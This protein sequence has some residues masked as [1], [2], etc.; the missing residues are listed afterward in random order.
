MT[1]TFQSNTYDTVIV[2]AGSAGCALAARLSEDS[3]RRVLLLE[4]GR[5]YGALNQY[6]WPLRCAYSNAFS[7]PGN[8]HSWTFY[9]ALASPEQRYPIT[10][11][12]V[13]GGSSAVNGSLFMRASASE[14]DAWAAQG[15]SEWSYAKVLP[16]LIR[17]E[18]DLDFGHTSLH[19]ETGP[20]P[21]MRNG[22]DD[23]CEV[24]QAFLEAC[25]GMGYPWDDDMND[26]SGRGGIGLLP[27]NAP[28]GLRQNTGACY[29]EPATHRRSLQVKPLATATKVLFSRG[30]AVGVEAVTGVSV[31]H[32]GADEVVLCAGGIKSP[33]LLM[34]SG[35]G[36]PKTLQRLGV[37]VIISLPNVGRNLMDH[38][39]VKLTYTCKSYTPRVGPR[40]L[41]EVA[42]HTAIEGVGA[43]AEVRIMPYVY[44]KANLLFATLPGLGVRERMAALGSVRNLRGLLAST[45]KLGARVLKSE[46][47]ELRALQIGISLGVERSRGEIRPLTSDWSQEPTISFG[48][49]THPDDIRRLRIGVRMAVAIFERKEFAARLGATLI[50]PSEDDLRNDETLDRWIRVHLT[51]SYHTASTCRMGA[52]R[53]IACE[54]GSVADQLGRVHGAEGLRI[55]DLSIL[56]KLV[57]RP[58]NS[59]AI[60]IGERI[61]DFMSYAKGGR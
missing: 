28:L 49:L 43:D 15:N 53:D 26:A 42:L 5:S 50:N 22:K 21:V 37:P 36:E 60:L 1:S 19:G 30:K 40:P 47:A 20:I 25:L 9:A 34:L 18:S 14:F 39:G 35:V 41:A 52:A 56:P 23:L 24:S 38:P 4:A 46:I 48:Y 58:T 55:A 17:Q 16:A 27:H 6:P 61:A 31:S 54:G 3:T 8:E 29:L 32:Y 57:S 2:G 11:G 45:G 44:N 59:T 7:A 33:H 51:T 13:V 12:K 10:R